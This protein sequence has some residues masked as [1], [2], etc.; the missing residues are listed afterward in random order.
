MVYECAAVLNIG[1]A[2]LEYLDEYDGIQHINFEVC[3]QNAARQ[4]KKGSPQ[5]CV[6]QRMVM[7]DQSGG[8]QYTL[9]FYTQ[10]PTIFAASSKAEI[11]RICVRI[12]ALGWRVTY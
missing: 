6:A 12:A 11:E 3:G 10:P 1:E 9:E 4:S 8:V 2:G 7:V 5:N